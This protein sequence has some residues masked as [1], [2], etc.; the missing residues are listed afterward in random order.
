M[1]SSED[2]QSIIIAGMKHTGKSTFIRE[3][4]IDKYVLAGKKVLII[5][6][7]SPTAYKGIGRLNSYNA[8]ETWIAQDEIKV[9]K[10][11]DTFNPMGMFVRL[12]Q[13]AM[14]EKLY[15]MLLVCEDA[16]AY[17]DAKP[18]MSQKAFLTNHRNSRLDVIYT[19]HAL[20]DVPKFMW[21]QT[22]MLIT[23]KTEDNAA[24]LLPE[25][26]KRTTHADKIYNTW[27]G[28]MKDKNQFAVDYIHL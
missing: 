15:N 1:S 21:R 25:M 2:Y 26:R 16:T 5:C 17:I 14:E 6:D 3:N 10:F 19:L 13:L 9:A 12:R 4:F 7:S 27:L 28:V 11:Y 20:I 23:K 22:T 8:I 18:T 24:T